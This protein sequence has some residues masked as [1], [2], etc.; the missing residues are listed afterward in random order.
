MGILIARGKGLA[1]QR[2]KQDVLAWETQAAVRRS[3][4][5]GPQEKR[6]REEMVH[7]EVWRKEVGGS[8]RSPFRV[9]ESLRLMP[10]WEPRSQ[11]CP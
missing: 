3:E 1:G 8:M 6:D 5:W 11:H 4:R 2:P 9:E 10:T 7:E